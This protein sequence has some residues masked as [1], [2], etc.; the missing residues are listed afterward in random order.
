MNKIELSSFFLTVGQ[1]RLNRK[2]IG[3]ILMTARQ[4]QRP[5]LEEQQSDPIEA[6]DDD[7][8]YC[9]CGKSY[10]GVRHI[11]YHKKW[12]CGKVLQ[13][14]ICCKILSTKYSFDHHMRTHQVRRDFF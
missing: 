10:T 9:K 6:S 8:L 11:R 4:N 2:L 3:Q 1:M 13:C 7:R 12:E 14:N 5:I